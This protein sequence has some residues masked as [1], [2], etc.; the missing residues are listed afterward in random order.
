MTSIQELERFFELDLIVK[1]LIESSRPNIYGSN[2]V[3]LEEDLLKTIET[4]RKAINQMLFLSRLDLEEE[5]NTRLNRIKSDIENCDFNINKLLF[6]Y[7][8]DILRMSDNFEESLENNIHGFSL[9]ETLFVPLRYCNTVNDM[10]HYVHF[11]VINNDKIMASMNLLDAKYEDEYN[12]GGYRLYGRESAEARN[13]FNNLP[14]NEARIDEVSFNNHILIMVRDRGHALSID[15]NK[16]N[17]DNYRVSYFIPKVC[18]VDMV[19]SIK[20]VKKINPDYQDSFSSTHGEFVVK[21]DNLGT[22]IRDFITS[23]PTDRN[24]NSTQDFDIGI[25]KL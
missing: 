12:I 13:I 20:G 22:E 21:K 14:E 24:I 5:F 16:E 2:V 17:D 15:I 23:V 8:N 25:R 7:E 3:D 9:Q 11:Y 4:F 10:L 19:N 1:K 6:T 18:N